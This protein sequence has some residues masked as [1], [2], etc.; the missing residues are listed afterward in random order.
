MMKKN[1]YII[2]IILTITLITCVACTPKNIGQEIPQVTMTMSVPTQTPTSVPPTLTA[3][4][5]HTPTPELKIGSTQVSA[6][7]GMTLLY[8]PAGEFQMGSTDAQFQAAKT[9]CLK[10]GGTKPECGSFSK[11]EPMHMVYLD[12]FWIDQTEVSNAMYMKC[13]SAGNCQVSKQKTNLI[14]DQK[15]VVEVNWSQAKTYC[16]WAGRGLPTEAQW[17]KAAR[18]TDGRS[19]PWG[20]GVDPSKANYNKSKIDQTS[21]I[22]NYLAGASPYGAL[23]MAGNIWEWV[24]DWDGSYSKETQRNPTGPT[25]GNDRVFRGGSF[26]DDELYIRTSMRGSWSPDFSVPSLGFRCVLNATPPN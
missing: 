3:T 19:Y 4:P 9:L 26:Q 25:S 16:E 18:G 6:I 13:V 17:E 11:E 22:G 24:A 12:A 8:I 5:A 21:N 20:E 15:P 1:V 2:Q 10:Q 14:D 7:D 23:D